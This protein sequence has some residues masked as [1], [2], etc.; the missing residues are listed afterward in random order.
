MVSV[1]F[2]S[3]AASTW[4]EVAALFNRELGLR[5]RLR[6]VGDWY[7][8]HG[9]ALDGVTREEAAALKELYRGVY[10]FTPL[11]GATYPGRV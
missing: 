3:P 1:S 7:D 11:A 8:P 10:V 6:H 9:F 4:R 2:V 5:V